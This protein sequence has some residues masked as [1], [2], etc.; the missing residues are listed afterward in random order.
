MQ[1]IYDLFINI[2][3]LINFEPDNNDIPFSSDDEIPNVFT[4]EVLDTAYMP[5]VSGALSGQDTYFDTAFVKCY[6]DNLYSRF[7]K[8]LG[9][10]LGEIFERLIGNVWV[11][12]CDCDCNYG[13]YVMSKEF[14][15]L[16]EYLFGEDYF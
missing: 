6:Q 3:D 13:H 1:K 8:Y 5:F 11:F 4:R 14:A 10:T 2:R 7:E 12:Y 9:L 16:P 15:K